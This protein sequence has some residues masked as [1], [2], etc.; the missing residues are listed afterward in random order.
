MSS[1]LE[2]PEFGHLYL[3]D[4]NDDDAQVIQSYFTPAPDGPPNVYKEPIPDQTVVVP[5]VLNRLLPGN[6]LIDPLWAQPSQILPSDEF[7]IMLMVKAFSTTATD[8]ILIADNPNAL[9]SP[10]GALLPKLGA[11]MLPADGWINL[12]PYTGALAATAFGAAAPVLFTWIAV[13][14]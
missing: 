4:T 14:K 6:Q 7:R 8:G 12:G 1:P 3:G 11:R 9:I 2:S 10:D 13:T 5:V